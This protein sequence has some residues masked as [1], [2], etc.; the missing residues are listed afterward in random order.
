MTLLV[1]VALVVVLGCVALV[2]DLIWLDMAST[3]MTAGVEAPALAAAKLLASDELLKPEQLQNINIQLQQARLAAG[4]LAADNHV[5]GTPI[6][7]DTSPDGDIQFGKLIEN[8]RTGHIEFLITSNSPTSVQV[9]GVRTKKRNNPVALFLQG[10]SG[11]EAGD[12]AVQTT[13]TIDNRILGLRPN[14]KFIIPALPFAILNSS[15]DPRQT[16]T[17]DIQIEQNLGTDLYSYN[18]E[19]HQVTLGSDGIPEITLRSIAVGKDSKQANV[20]LIDMNNNLRDYNIIQQIK[21]GWQEE[22]LKRLGGELRIDRGVIPFKSTT[23]IP[24]SIAQALAGMIGQCRIVSLFNNHIPYGKQ[25]QGKVELAGLV[26]GRVMKVT[27]LSG[28]ETEIIFQPGV[29]T[30]RSAIL[31]NNKLATSNRQNRQNVKSNR[32]IYKLYLTH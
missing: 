25:G 19:T 27:A 29:L 1:V 20:L 5:A 32:Y 2:L 31:P 24:S 21:N 10:I 26:A 6:Q 13:A 14:G 23:V 7:L 3:E 28:T 17:W 18:A 9:T 16:E 12:V 22:D 15:T 4:Q 11:T 8:S 30:T